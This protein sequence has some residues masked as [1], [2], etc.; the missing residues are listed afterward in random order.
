MEILINNFFSVQFE[1][2]G[3]LLGFLFLFF[4]IIKI[5]KLT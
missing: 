2:I 1:L 3:Y 5:S 4:L